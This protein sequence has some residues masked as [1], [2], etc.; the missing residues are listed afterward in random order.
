LRQWNEFLSEFEVLNGLRVPRCYFKEGLRPRHYELHGFS[1]ASEHA[2]AAAVYL[3]TTYT[4]GSISV[5]LIASKT[6]VSPV[7]K[8]S[9]PRLELLG[10]QILTRLTDTVLNQLPLQLRATY[11]VD[12]TT[13][14]YWI[15]N[16]RPW[17]QY[18]LRTISE[19]RSLTMETLSWSCQ[20]SRPSFS[21]G[22]GTEVA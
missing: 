4:D 6:R 11:R 5:T 19:I 18:V 15:K 3:R 14:L 1:D 16:Q 9:I 13:I 22:G 20:P 8:Q 12:S 17:K 10:A 2:Y 21:W 7:K